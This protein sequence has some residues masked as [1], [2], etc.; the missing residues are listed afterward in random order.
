MV[1]EET[2]FSSQDLARKVLLN[3]EKSGTEPLQPPHPRPA[4]E[5]RISA[6]RDPAGG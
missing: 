6:P 5:Q 2:V 1:E 3:G 4:A